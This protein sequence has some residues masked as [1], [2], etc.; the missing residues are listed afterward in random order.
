VFVTK[1]LNEVKI[2]LD[3]YQNIKFTNA[4]NLIH[5]CVLR[6]GWIFLGA[7]G[8]SQ[9]IIEHFSTDWSKGIFEATSIKVKTLVLNNN[10]SMLTAISN[11]LSYDDS[12][13]M[14]LEIFGG[15]N[16]LLILV[17]S[18]GQSKNIIKGHQTAKSLGI[19]TISLTGFGLNSKLLDSTVSL[20][21]DTEDYQV[22][23]DVH[24]V[25]GH[26]VYKYFC[27]L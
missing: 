23:E 16:D 18:S 7:N 10:L 15:S 17:S 6:K 9:S 11:D 22:I 20:N 2:Q 14:P 5:E 26:L 3:L 8:G 25:F 13:S 19:S 24:S 21:W 12:I 4:C 1:H 27:S